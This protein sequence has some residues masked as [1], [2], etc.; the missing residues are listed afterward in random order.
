MNKA[1]YF[2]AASDMNMKENWAENL[3]NTQAKALLALLSQ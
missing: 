1:R 2:K 3:I